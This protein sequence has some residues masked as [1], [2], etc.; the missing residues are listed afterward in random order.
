VSDEQVV[1]ALRTEYETLRMPSGSN[2]ANVTREEAARL[3]D[4]TTDHIYQGDTFQTLELMVAPGGWNLK[5]CAHAR[6]RD[7]ARLRI[8]KISHTVDKPLLVAPI[9]ELSKFSQRDAILAGSAVALWAIPE[10][11]PLDDACAVD[12]RLIQPIASVTSVMTPW[13]CIGAE[14]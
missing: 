12:F 14:L 6:D 8:H 2:V 7:L 10:A 4:G 3:F 5:A 11:S 1:E 9:R 13:T